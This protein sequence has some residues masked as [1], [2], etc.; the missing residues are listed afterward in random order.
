MVANNNQQLFDIQ[1]RISHL[2]LHNYTHS[3]I[4]VKISLQEELKDL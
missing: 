4:K 3:M 2:G 1:L